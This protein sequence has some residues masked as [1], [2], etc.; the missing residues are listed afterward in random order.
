[1]AICTEQY[2]PSLLQTGTKVTSPNS[3]YSS[4]DRAYDYFNDALFGGTLPGAL[5]TL[6]DH[7]R[8][9]GYFR[10]KAFA[11][12]SEAEAF[13]DEICLCPSTHAGRS[14]HDILSTLVHEMCHLWQFHKG[15][16]P[17]RCYH[18]R[19][20][21]AKMQ[22]VGLMPS[23][24]GL[25]G[26]KKT[27]QS[28]THYI[29]A[30]GPFDLVCQELLATGWQLLWE[31]PRQVAPAGGTKGA[32]GGETQKSTRQKFSCPQCKL[33]AYAKPTARLVCGE[34]QVEMG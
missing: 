34:C 4:L 26:G 29:V 14:D 8:A 30:G 10:R 6:H 2:T 33:A 31:Q 28:M 19:Q 20:F 18:D 7:P 23:D 15:E 32:S 13:T 27:G 17:R 16:P 21:A 1:M 11:H 22:E 24:T 25:P 3:E 12:R 5:I 9:R